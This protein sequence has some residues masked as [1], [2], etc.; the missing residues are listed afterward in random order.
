M[1][2]ETKVDRRPCFTPEYQPKRKI[3]DT[4]KLLAGNTELVHTYCVYVTDVSMYIYSKTI[5]CRSQNRI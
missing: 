3:F 1:A 4:N 5:L 2:E